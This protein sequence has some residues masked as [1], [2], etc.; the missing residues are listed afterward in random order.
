NEAGQNDVYGFGFFC[1]AYDGTILLVANTEQYHLSNLQDFE[2][3]VGPTDPEVYKWDIGNWKYPGGLFPSASAEQREFDE[4]WQEFQKPLSR[5]DHDEKQA[6]LEE[7][8]VEVL[9]RLIN[10]GTFWE[11]TCGW[12]F[13]EPRWGKGRSHG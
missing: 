11:T 4:A 8:C 10:E 3:R 12:D 5:I 1:D 6:R 7:V 2:A 13:R 9:R